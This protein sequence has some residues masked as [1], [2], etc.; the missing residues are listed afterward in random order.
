MKEFLQEEF[1]EAGWKL[2]K[3]IK[4]DD[5]VEA[6]SQYTENDY[7][8]WIKDNFKSFFDHGRP[9]WKWIMLRIRDLEFRP[10]VVEK[11]SKTGEV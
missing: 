7:Y 4:W 10:K 8:E 6:F 3:K 1:K 11:K 2:P 9:N 5:L